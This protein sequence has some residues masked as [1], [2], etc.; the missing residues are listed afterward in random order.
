ML[1]GFMVFGLGILTGIL[2]T[3][4]VS[5]IVTASDDIDNHTDFR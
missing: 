5:L 2:I 3:I 1:G 4:G